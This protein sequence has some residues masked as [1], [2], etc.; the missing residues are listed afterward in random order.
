MKSCETFF[1]KEK[2]DG[3]KEKLEININCSGVFVERKSFA[4]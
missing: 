1:L 3:E 2:L 4:E